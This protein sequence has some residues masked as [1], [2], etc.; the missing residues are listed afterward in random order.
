VI[1]SLHV[2][3]AKRLQTGLRSKH[4][5]NVTE[6]TETLFS[7]FLLCGRYNQPHYG[8]C[9]SIILSSVY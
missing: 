7:T 5:A 9:L 8:S 1:T 2:L 3:Y 6:I 4:F